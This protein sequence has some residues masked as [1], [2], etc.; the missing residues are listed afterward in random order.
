MP[1]SLEQLVHRQV[2]RWEEE[3]RSAGRPVGLPPG[4]P[5]RP[6]ITVSREYGARGAAVGTRVA[7]RLGFE[8]YG[9]ELVDYIAREA[10]VQRRVVETLDEHVVAALEESIK[11]QLGADTLSPGAYRHDLARVVWALALRGRGVILGRGAQFIL[12]PGWTLRVRAIAPVE[13]RRARVGDLGRIDRER[14][15]FC[16]RYFG[17]DPSDPHHYDLIVNTGTMSEETCAEV[18]I[19]AYRAKFE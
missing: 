9:R 2:M 16:R 12:D 5:H 6:M 1:H 3:E 17:R 13:V 15:E 4:A 19:A 10:H 14:D 8:L 18:V 11:Q 7:E